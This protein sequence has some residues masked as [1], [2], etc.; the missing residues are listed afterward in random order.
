MHMRV[1]KPRNNRAAAES[2]HHRFG[3]D[4]AAHFIVRSHRDES[5]VLDRHGFFHLE[6]R[7]HGHHFTIYKNPFSG[8]TGIKKRL[9]NFAFM[10]DTRS[11]ERGK[12]DEK[13]KLSRAAPDGN[14]TSTSRV[15][16][17]E[18]RRAF[19]HRQRES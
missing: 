14:R 17:P 11:E 12:E 7:I 19:G 2:H 6:G 9:R 3:S 1:N 16:I 10:A 8:W 13:Q 15:K 5:T 4:P 18:I